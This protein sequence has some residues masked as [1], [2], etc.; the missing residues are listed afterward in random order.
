[1]KKPNITEGEWKA[2]DKAS[3]DVFDFTANGKTLFQCSGF[4]QDPD[5]QITLRNPNDA[6]AISAVPE[7]IDALSNVHDS[8]IAF[9]DHG[10]KDI[11]EGY[12]RADRKIIE[13]ALEKA[14]CHD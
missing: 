12:L 10:D 13:K 4:L 2:P 7:M 9:L 8:I 14:G 1:M 3:I 11:I 5:K 6:K